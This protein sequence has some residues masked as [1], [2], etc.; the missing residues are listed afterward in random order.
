MKT[1]RK[2]AI[3]SEDEDDSFSKETSYKLDPNNYKLLD[4]K[5]LSKF[6]EKMNTRPL[7]KADNKLR[8]SLAGAQEKLALAKINGELYLP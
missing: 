4:C 3:L 1:R 7:I 6:I 5:R 8:L 2:T